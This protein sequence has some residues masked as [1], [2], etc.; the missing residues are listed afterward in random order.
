MIVAALPTVPVSNSDNLGGFAGPN[1]A[2]TQ[3]ARNP[4]AE[5]SLRKNDN[6][7]YRILGT[8]Y[9]EYEIID[10]LTYRLNLGADCHLGP[11]VQLLSQV[12]RRRPGPEHPERNF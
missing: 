4:V 5:A 11:A 12:F 2:D 3:D 9:G 8:V 1:A 7:R 10:G 6:T